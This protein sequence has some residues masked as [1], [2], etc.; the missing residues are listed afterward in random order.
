MNWTHVLRAG[1]VAGIV[2]NLADFVMHG[3]IMANTYVKY[4]QVFSQTQANPLWFL[5]VAL[6]LGISAAILFGKSRASWAPGWKGGATFG[7]FLGLVGFW[8]GFYNPL[9]ID[10][11]PYYLCWCWGGITMIDSLLAGCVLGAMIKRT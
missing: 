4:S 1:V 7:F 6:C 3:M 9:V 5:L 8:T 11:F 10:G 2:T